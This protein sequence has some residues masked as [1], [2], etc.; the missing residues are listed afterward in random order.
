MENLSVTVTLPSNKSLKKEKGPGAGAQRVK[1]LSAPRVSC[2][3]ASS[4]RLLHFRSSPA[5]DPGRPRGRPECLGSTRGGDLALL[6][7]GPLE[8]RVEGLSLPL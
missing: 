8:E 1:P 4:V 2:R 3:A 5:E 7:P 6:Q